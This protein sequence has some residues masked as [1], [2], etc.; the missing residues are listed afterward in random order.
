MPQPG[1]VGHPDA[2][3]LLLT[4]HGSDDVLPKLVVPGVAE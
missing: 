1:T 2:E 4:L 3:T